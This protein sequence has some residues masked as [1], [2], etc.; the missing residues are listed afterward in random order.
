MSGDRFY[1]DTITMIIEIGLTQILLE[2]M[3]GCICL[4][5]LKL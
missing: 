5:E 3:L 2:Q 4:I 1:L